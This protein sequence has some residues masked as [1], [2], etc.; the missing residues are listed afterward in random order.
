MFGPDFTMKWWLICHNRDQVNAILNRFM[1]FFGIN[2]H[3]ALADNLKIHQSEV[4]NW[5]RSNAFPLEIFEKVIWL[6][7][8]NPEWLISGE[9]DQ[10]LDDM[11]DQQADYMRFSIFVRAQLKYLLANYQFTCL[12]HG[13]VNTFAANLFDLQDHSVEVLVA[14]MLRRLYMAGSVTGLPMN[15]LRKLPLDVEYSRAGIITRA[16]A[17]S[18]MDRPAL[19][20][21]VARYIRKEHV[22]AEEADEILQQVEA[23][24]LEFPLELLFYLFAVLGVNIIYVLTGLGEHRIPLL[25]GNADDA[26]RESSLEEHP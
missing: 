11:P 10:L 13:Y 4:S 7:G 3:V 16:G 26:W 24:E 23:G 2:T 22:D 17:A 1:E 19:A 12:P 18:G 5:K 9:G 20:K 14:E 6:R 21:A 8:L 15:E 25:P